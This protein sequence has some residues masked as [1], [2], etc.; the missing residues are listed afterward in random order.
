MDV[1]NWIITF[2]PFVSFI[3][4]FL[5]QK[6][7]HFIEQPYNFSNKKLQ[8]VSKNSKCIPR[9]LKTMDKHDW[10]WAMSVFD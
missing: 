6:I 8:T 10:K 7:T 3:N 9:L 4:F 2:I 1:I 5:S